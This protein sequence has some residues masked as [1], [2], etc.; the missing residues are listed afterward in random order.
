M[1]TGEELDLP[2]HGS[3]VY[4]ERRNKI[5]DGELRLFVRFQ[6]LGVFMLA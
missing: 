3:W 4:W 2:A 5:N 1:A 6:G